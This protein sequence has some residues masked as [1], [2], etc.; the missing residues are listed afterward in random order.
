MLNPRSP[1]LNEN[2]FLDRID[3][4]TIKQIKSPTYHY[5]DIRTIFK[6]IFYS[7]ALNRLALYKNQICSGALRSGVSAMG[8]SPI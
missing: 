6:E 4:P 2:V 1:S 7:L 8:L 5:G 3:Q